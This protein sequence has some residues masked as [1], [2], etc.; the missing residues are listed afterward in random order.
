[1]KK[2]G[3]Y[4]FCDESVKKD[5]YYS[6][7][8]GGAIINKSDYLATNNLLNSKKQYLGMEDSE[9]K[10]TNINTFRINAYCEMMDV[11]FELI[12]QDVLKV[13][14]MFTD[15]RF[16]PSNLSTEQKHNEYHLLYYQFI[17]HAFGL[18]HLISDVPLSLELFF[19]WIPE[20]KE[21]NTKFKN[22]IHAI[23]HLPEF[24][25]T[26]IEI[27]KDAIAEVDSKNFIVMQCVDVVLGAMA[28]RLN[29]HHKDIPEGKKRR[30]KRTVAKEMVYKHIYKHL[31]EIRPNFNVGMST[32]LNGN[33][34][35]Y[36]FHLY[37][38]WLFVPSNYDYTKR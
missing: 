3:Y 13:R 15:N 36:F 12:K 21:K 30:G 22:F 16:S 4:I 19:D 26:N 10:W 2:A 5:R 24:I 14:I 27:R 1:M 29:K 20:K 9:L 32:G 31:N 7:F 38:H 34:Q 18:K 11:F 17:K 35:N 8:Y 33:A 23:Q 37:R 25:D 6:N 28:F